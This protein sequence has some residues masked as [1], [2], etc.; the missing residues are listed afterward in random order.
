MNCVDAREALLEAE[1]PM[2]EGGNSSPLAK[3]LHECANCGALAVALQNQHQATQSYY[4][5][6]RPRMSSDALATAVLDGPTVLPMR[7]S[8]AAGSVLHVSQLR[9]P[10]KRRGM[11]AA[12]F[13]GASIAAGMT[14]FVLHRDAT[15]RRDAYDRESSARRVPIE[16]EVPSNQNAI[17]FETRNPNITVVWIYSGD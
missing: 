9:S 2:A 14:L 10:G 4:Q 12:A 1:L 11:V 6:L 7:R 17:V 8:T 16:V 15:G 3:H 5:G 13:L